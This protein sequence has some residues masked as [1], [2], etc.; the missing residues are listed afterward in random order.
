MPQD[1][2]EENPAASENP[3]SEA[4]NPRIPDHEL[5]RC[6]GSGA[7]GEVWLASATSLPGSYRAVKI[8]RRDSLRGDG[9]AREFRG[10][11][12][13]E[14]IS[15]SHPNLVNILHVGENAKE[16]YFFY[17]M[18]LAD[19]AFPASDPEAITTADAVL[20]RSP[21]RWKHPVNPLTYQ[22]K[23]LQAELKLRGRLPFEE[24]LEIAISLAAGLA[25][26][27][28]HSLIHRDI[29]PANIIFVHGTAKLA[30]IGLVADTESASTFVGTAGYIP[31]EG[32][33]APQADIYS[34]GKVL[35]EMATGLDRGRFPQLPDDWMDRGEKESLLGFNQIILRACEFDASNRYQ[36]AEQLG[37][38]LRRLRHGL[39]PTSQTPARERKL[40]W[41][42]GIAAA[43]ALLV[44]GGFVFHKFA[45]GLQG[46]AAG[47]PH[48]DRA[49]EKQTTSGFK[50]LF[51]G[52]DL[53]GWSAP[54]NN[55]AGSEG[56]LTRV[57]SGGDITY[58]DEQLPNDF[59]LQFE[60]KVAA[61]GDSGILYRPGRV[62]YQI[63]DN[64]G[65]P[66]GSDRRTW[67]GSL[68][69]YSSQ[70]GSHAKSAGEWNS[71]R[72]MCEGDRIRHY[73]NGALVLDTR[74]TQPEWDED[75]KRLRDKYN[76][77]LAARGGFLVLRD[78]T[79]QVWFRNIRLKAL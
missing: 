22:A 45:A 14:P 69:D 52:K 17:V 56:S 26:L 34:L 42:L 36:S 31:P 79:G 40:L 62:E 37:D 46:T 33:G 76:T 29:K 18:E 44:S 72:V 66:L 51:N 77:D 70:P 3:I 2:R 49:D 16:G 30:D 48:S 20:D 61:G 1:G 53:T 75:R 55:W 67:A 74:Y 63:L 11:Q 25:H 13:F 28:R 59:D 21:A 43:L 78:E 41:A 38:D 35:Y 23:T 12:K 68:F 10:I 6:V 64:A 7:F 19:C 65:S 24:C 8:V 54:G 32:P 73:L 27:H 47:Q 71:G 4:G 50:A 39:A 15:R 57:G 5:I 58:E 60:W 9:F